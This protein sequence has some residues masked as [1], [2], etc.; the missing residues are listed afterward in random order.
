MHTITTAAIAIATAFAAAIL[1]PSDRATAAMF[2]ATAFQIAITTAAASAAAA[3]TTTRAVSYSVDTTALKNFVLT[4]FV[5]I[6]R[7]SK[8]II[9]AVELLNFSFKVLLLVM[10]IL[11]PWKQ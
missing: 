8:Y 10:L 9:V 6:C 4:F 1:I 3:A 11:V 5:C 7:W 2:V